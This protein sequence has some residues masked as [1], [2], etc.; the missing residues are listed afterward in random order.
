MRIAIIGCNGMLGHKLFTY[1]QEDSSLKV[2]GI[3]NKRSTKLKKYNKSI[4]DGINFLDYENLLLSISNIN[5]E[6][7]INCAGII[8][9]KNQNVTA[10]DEIK[11][12]SLLPHIIADF[13]EKN[14]KRLIHFSTDHNYNS[15]TLNLFVSYNKEYVATVYKFQSVTMF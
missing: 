5:P 9:Q 1:L 8:K 3:C 7:I 14:S 10:I 12:N 13:C 15:S 11:I 6:L 4:I 2:F